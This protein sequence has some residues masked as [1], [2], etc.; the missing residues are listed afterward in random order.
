MSDTNQEAPS[1][2]P[3]ETAECFAEILERH[4]SRRQVLAG[5]AAAPLLTLPVALAA[6]RDASAAS[7][8]LTFSPV[9]ETMRDG[10]FVPDGYTADIVIRWGDPLAADLGL[11]DVKNQTPGDMARR[12]GFNN[13]MI[14]I[15]PETFREPGAPGKDT[16]FLMCV[17]QEFATGTN[18]FP[19]YPANGEP[20]RI[21]AMCQMESLGVTVVRIVQKNGAWTYDPAS[22]FNRRITA[23]TPIAIT[24]PAA[25][26]AL[27][28]TPA[29]PTGTRV[30]GT[31][32]NCSGGF[33]PWGTYLSGEENFNFN[34]A[35][36]ASVADANT[37]SDHAD[38]RL[39]VDRSE[40][41]WEA[42][43][44]RFDVARPEG[45]NEPYRFG[46]VVEI[47]PYDPASTPKKRTALGRCKHEA[48]QMALTRSGQAVV[49]TGDDEPFEYVYK[50]VS[51][52]RYRKGDRQANMDLLDRGTLF[53]ARFYDD[54]SGVWLALDLDDGESG[55]RL[56]AAK[57]ADGSPRFPTQAEVSIHTRRAGDA[58]GATPM[59]RPEDIEPLRDANF[60]GTGKV[61][62]VLTGNPGRGGGSAPRGRSS[63]RNEANP[64]RNNRCG[65]ILEITENGNDHAARKF[66]WRIF[67]LA[68]DPAAAEGDKEWVNQTFSGDRFA[69][70]DNV[71]F[72]NAHN[73]WIATDGN[74]KSFASGDSVI[75]MPTSGASNQPVV[76]KRFLV[77][78]PASEVCGPLVTPDE[79]TFFCAIQ[80]PGE[81]TPGVIGNQ[82]STWPNGDYPRPSVV[83]VRRLDGGRVGS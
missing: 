54:G 9:P 72:D 69:M 81:E 14:A 47:D 73:I 57:N 58:V 60:V 2:R 11:F 7:G 26:H 1:A 45:L 31:Y 50:F 61:F 23:T 56:K 78:P 18:M 16:A 25:G 8:A 13:D 6:S 80:H 67:A 48:A 65:H 34:F 41:R 42:Y 52:G 64:R 79:R 55:P 30:L 77:S 46:Y 3:R 10:L 22:K 24:G 62:V 17:N 37:R 36:A 51:S 32:A 15:F 20:T 63:D 38:L 29:D 75:V 39:S 70:P 44:P 53:A 40:A 66:A 74:D 49:Y 27:L 43:D 71:C 82:R 28:K 76:A 59:D 5:A 21:H 12:F 35:G 68:G 33:T 83:A 4:L 19:D